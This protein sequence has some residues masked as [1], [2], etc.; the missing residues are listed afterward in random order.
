MGFADAG[1]HH[2]MCICLVL[3]AKAELYAFICING[4]MWQLWDERASTGLT[5][6]V[7]G[8]WMGAVQVQQDVRSAKAT[9]PCQG[10]Y[11]A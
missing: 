7:A 2:P 6:S 11:D 4:Q 10:M 5:C 9:L 3:L 1:L 8:A